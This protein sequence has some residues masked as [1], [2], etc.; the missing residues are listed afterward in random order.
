MSDKFLDRYRN[1][2]SRL[3]GW[4]YSREG[5]YFIT[6]CTA[7]REC[8]FGEIY[9]KNMKLSEIGKIVEME[10]EKSFTIR[11]ELNCAIYTIMPNHIHTILRIGHDSRRGAR[12][13]VPTDNNSRTGVA[14]RSPKSISS[15]VAGF[16]ASATKRINKYRTSP[17]EPVWQSRFYDHIIQNKDE[18]LRIRQYIKDNPANW[19]IDRFYKGE[20]G[21]H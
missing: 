6:I 15:F 14:Y 16:K 11:T 7:N 18:Y 20:E 2:S 19:E 9:N 17:G 21:L 5:V 4:D 1:E 12:P 10:W 8:L 13:Y 3:P